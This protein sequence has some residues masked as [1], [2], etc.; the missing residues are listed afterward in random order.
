MIGRN[1]VEFVIPDDVSLTNSALEHAAKNTLPTTENRYRHKDGGFRWMSWLAAPEG[2]LIFATGRHITAEKEAAERL[3]A[4]E[5]ALRQAR[6][7]KRS[8]SSRAASR[9]TSTI[10]WPAS[11]GSLELLQTRLAQGR[12]ERCRP[13]SQRG[14]GRGRRAAGLTQRLLAFSRRQTL[15]P[16][17]ADVNRLIAGMEELIRRT[18]GPAIQIE[19]VGGGRALDHAGRC[20]PA[21]ERAAQSVHQCARCHARWRQADDRDRQ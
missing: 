18:V 13:L 21:R 2:D 19:V 10:S 17:P 16:K 20:R 12:I 9:T 4:S 1:V 11:C 15:D 7:W 8:A 5:A 14:A 3:A 6:K